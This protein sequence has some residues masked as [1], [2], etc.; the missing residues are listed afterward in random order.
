MRGL[1]VPAGLP[2]HGSSGASISLAV[3]LHPMVPLLVTPCLTQ[4]LEAAMQQAG[5]GPLQYQ[6]LKVRIRV[7]FLFVCSHACMGG[8]DLLA[9]SATATLGQ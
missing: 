9:S 1:S 6:A 2:G 3:R 8:C 4:G 7:P 5:E